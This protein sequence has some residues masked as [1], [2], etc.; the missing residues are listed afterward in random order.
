MFKQFYLTDRY[1]LDLTMGQVDLGA[2]PMKEYSA[3]FNGPALLELHHQI[4]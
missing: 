2:M 1:D 4:V 3:F